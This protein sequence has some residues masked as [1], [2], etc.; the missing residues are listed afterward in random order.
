MII[1]LELDQKRV[2]SIGIIIFGRLARF[3]VFSNSCWVTFVSSIVHIKN[4]CFNLFMY[5]RD[6]HLCSIFVFKDI[7]N[8]ELNWF[9]SPGL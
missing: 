4:C 9:V 7:N 2:I 5:L 6:S 3:H 8:V 1:N